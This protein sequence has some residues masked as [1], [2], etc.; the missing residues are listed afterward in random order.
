MENDRTISGV[1]GSVLLRFAGD[2]FKGRPS[3]MEAAIERDCQQV[4][5]DLEFPERSLHK[6]LGL[7]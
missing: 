1:P 5:D 3:P 7:V 2:H 4:D 6:L